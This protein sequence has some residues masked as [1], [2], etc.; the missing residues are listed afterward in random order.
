MIQIGATPIKWHSSLEWLS[1][2]RAWERQN[3]FHSEVYECLTS[4]FS[5]AASLSVGE[6]TSGA[7]TPLSNFQ[8]DS[9]LLEKLELKYEKNVGWSVLGS[10]PRRGIKSQDQG[11]NKHSDASLQKKCVKLIH[12]KRKSCFYRLK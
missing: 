11:W 10:S 9:W 6:Q 5:G 7:E 3:T 8:Q 1:V 4:S 12:F 2:I